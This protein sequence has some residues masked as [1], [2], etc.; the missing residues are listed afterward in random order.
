ME[1]DRVASLEQVKKFMLLAGWSEGDQAVKEATEKLEAAKQLKLEGKPSWI[2]HKGTSEKLFKK[3]QLLEK[4][5]QRE[6]NIKLEIEKLQE[7][8]I[9]IQK[10]KITL[11]TEIK[12]LEEE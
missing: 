6:T 1:M 9:Q 7:E 3:R 12:E 10:D 4:G 2:R 11:G 5:D 8:A